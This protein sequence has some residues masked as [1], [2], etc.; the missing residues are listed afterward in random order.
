MQRT[1]IYLSEAELEG[2]RGLA[3]RSG[4]SQSSLIREAIDSFLEQRQPQDRLARL[5]QGRALWAGGSARFDGGSVRH[6]LDR[7]AP[8]GA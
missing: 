8:E 5:R 6:E 7:I 4:R 3:Q 1:Q 2:L